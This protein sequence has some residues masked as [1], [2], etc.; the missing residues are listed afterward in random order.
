MAVH[1]YYPTDSFGYYIRARAR[2]HAC[3]SRDLERAR[4]RGTRP[5]RFPLVWNHRRL[6]SATDYLPPAEYERAYWRQQAE[7]IEAA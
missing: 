6:H 7:P 1:H 3:R 5:V 4:R 2:R